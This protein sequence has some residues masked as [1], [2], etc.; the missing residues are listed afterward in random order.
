MNLN[1]T[2]KHHI[3]D[4]NCNSKNCNSHNDKYEKNKNPYTLLMEILKDTTFWKCLQA[5][6]QC[7]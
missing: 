6:H 2:M 7:T 4:K 1:P 3:L 5:N